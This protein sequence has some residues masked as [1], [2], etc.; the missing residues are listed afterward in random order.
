VLLLFFIFIFFLFV[1][2]TSL[3]GHLEKELI[4]QHSYYY[5]E[6]HTPVKRSIYMDKIIH[7]EKE[8]THVKTNNKKSSIYTRARLSLQ[9]K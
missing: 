9:E 3:R 7:K 2:C 4:Q 1:F 6:Q 5:V 8:L